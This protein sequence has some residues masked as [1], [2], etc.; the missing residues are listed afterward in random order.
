MK[1]G[2]R[3]AN[4]EADQCEF[5]NML[6]NFRTILVLLA[7]AKIDTNSSLIARPAE[8][9][10]VMIEVKHDQ[11]NI[12]SIWRVATGWRASGYSLSTRWYANCIAGLHYTRNTRCHCISSATGPS[13]VEDVLRAMSVLNC[14][15]RIMCES[16]STSSSSPHLCF[17]FPDFNPRDLPQKTSPCKLHR[18]PRDRSESLVYRDGKR[19]ERT[20]PCVY[21]IKYSNKRRRLAMVLEITREIKES[22]CS[23]THFLISVMARARP[24]PRLLVRMTMFILYDDQ[25]GCYSDNGTWICRWS[26]FAWDWPRTVNHHLLRV[27]EI[28]AGSLVWCI[29]V[30]CVCV[31]YIYFIR[32]NWWK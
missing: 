18:S 8:P 24:V 3:S 4:H 11:C 15:V 5:R 17:M 1:A 25:G 31:V 14:I 29:S 19:K 22:R 16:C 21:R 2:S 27:I 10:T 28:D 6:R 12:V 23:I 7:I 30:A 26:S 32:Q 13:V 9:I 20:W